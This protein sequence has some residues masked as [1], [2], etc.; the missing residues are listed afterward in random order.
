MVSMM[1]ETAEEAG[2]VAVEEVVGEVQSISTAGA[3]TYC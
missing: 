2:D 3:R 1:T